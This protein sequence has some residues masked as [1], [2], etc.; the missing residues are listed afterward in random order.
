MDSIFFSKIL[1]IIKSINFFG[2]GNFFENESIKIF[3]SIVVLFLLRAIIQAIF[4]LKNAQLAYGVEANLSKEI[5]RTYLSKD[6][7]FFL[8]NNP[9]FLLRN[10][11]TETNKF[12]LGILANFTSMFTEIFII[13]ALVVLGFITNKYFAISAFVFLFFLD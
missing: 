7:N 2:L 3:S 10:I 13:I 4:V 12:C 8:K 6:Y 11:I 1:D 5:F 9:S